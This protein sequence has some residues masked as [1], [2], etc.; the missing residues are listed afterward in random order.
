MSLEYSWRS[1]TRGVD[2]IQA[3]TCGLLLKTQGYKVCIVRV[4]TPMKSMA[5]NRLMCEQVSSIKIGEAHKVMLSI[6]DLIRR[7]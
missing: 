7:T 1:C 6:N 4:D 2:V 3:S 5:R